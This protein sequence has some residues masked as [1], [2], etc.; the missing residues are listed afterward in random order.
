MHRL[1]GA[2]VRANAHQRAD[3]LWSHLE[4]FLDDLGTRIEHEA[5]PRP[6]DPLFA[7]YPLL[8]DQLEFLISDSAQRLSSALLRQ[9][10][11]AATLEGQHG[12]LARALTLSHRVLERKQAI[13][14]A[15]PDNE[16]ATRDLSVSQNKLGDFHLQRGRRGD[17]D[18]AL[19]Y[20]Q[21]DLATA[22]ELYRRNPDSAQAARDLSVSQNKLGDFHLQRGGRGDADTALGY[23]QAALATREALYHR[24]P[25]SALAARDVCVSLFNLG[26]VAHERGDEAG[27]RSYAQRLHAVL[28]RIVRDGL[29]LDA[30]MQGLYEQLEQ[31]FSDDSA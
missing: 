23:Y 5:Q 4:A 14:A 1:I 2:H 21:A 13:H 17:A 19:G 12:S 15:D 9:A 29:A 31:R 8:R 30:S 18:T 16:E 27:E 28:S 11:M 20:Y 3:T 25:D 24:N 10:Q 26:R 22:E 7:Q 6:D